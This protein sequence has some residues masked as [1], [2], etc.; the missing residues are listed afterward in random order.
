MTQ[1]QAKA[2]ERI[3]AAGRERTGTL[4]AVEIKTSN[5]IEAGKHLIYT[6][7]FGY[8]HDEESMLSV[9]GRSSGVFLIGPQGAIKASS[10][11]KA[12]NAQ[13]RKYPLVYGWR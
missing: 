12:T 11:G 4:R 9:I 3:N 7:E 6:V 2:I 1:Q 8:E 5:L 10:N 13:L